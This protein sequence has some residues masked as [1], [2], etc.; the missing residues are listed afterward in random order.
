[1]NEVST[2][3]LESM[4]WWDAYFSPGGGWEKNGGREQTR[5]FAETFCK[6]VRLPLDRGLKLLDVGCALGEAIRVFRRE[7]PYAELAGI[8]LSPVAINRCRADLGKLATFSVGSIEEIEGDYDVIY[9]SN[10]LEHFADY[11]QRAR[12]LLKKCRRLCI[13]VPFE[14]RENGVDLHPD[15]HKQHQVTFGKNSFDFLLHEGDALTIKKHIVA[16]PGAWGF[17]NSTL[18]K[19]I[20]LKLKKTIVKMHGLDIVNEYY[21]IIYD[22]T[23]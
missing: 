17:N 20:K 10:V 14:E 15:P 11:R 9:V 4:E 23:A 7:Y 21:Q 1:M 18:I 13:M 19:R 3:Q 2:H 22:I 6:N 12:H 16:C 8:D 5:I